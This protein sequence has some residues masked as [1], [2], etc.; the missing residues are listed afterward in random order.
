M[1]PA[2]SPPAPPILKP[3]KSFLTVVPPAFIVLLTDFS[4]FSPAELTLFHRS[5]REL[6]SLSR[7][8]EFQDAYVAN[9]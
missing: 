3:H 9:H 1:P 5:L 8:K 2:T 4:H 6:G 7:I